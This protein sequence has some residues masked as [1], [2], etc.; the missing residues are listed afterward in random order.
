M[1]YFRYKF[2]V[3]V[4]LCDYKESYLDLRKLW[5]DSYIE[6]KSTRHAIILSDSNYDCDYHAG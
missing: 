5:H 2:E 4:C 6:E 1:I 3:Q